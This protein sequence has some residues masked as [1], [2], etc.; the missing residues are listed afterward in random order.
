MKEVRKHAAEHHEAHSR[1]IVGMAQHPHKSEDK[2]LIHT[3]A[4]HH[5]RAGGHAPAHSDV[6]E[7]KSLV[8]K[9]VKPNALTG[10]ACGGKMSRGG[11]PSKKGG[12]TQVNVLVGGNKPNGSAPPPNAPMPMPVRAPSPPIGNPAGPP[13]GGGLAALRG[14]PM[15]PPGSKHGGKVKHRSAG[16][17]VA[18]PTW[19]HAGAGSGD[20]RL[21][22]EKAYGVKSKTRD[23]A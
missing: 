12:K 7:D 6:A 2:K 23:R 11:S 17:R 22:K 3:L 13:M 8:R 21:E 5:R 4:S 14:A 9:M 10:K 20:G 19:Q 15:P 1:K 18:R 16:G